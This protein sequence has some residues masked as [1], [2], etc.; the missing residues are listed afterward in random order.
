MTGAVEYRRLVGELAAA[1][2]RRDMELAAAEGS[3]V[4][5]MAALDK[6]TVRA[7]A[8]VDAAGARVAAARAGIEA[9]DHTAARLWEAL[10]TQLGWR[11]RL[12]AR[13]RSVW[14]ESPAPS[15][16]PVEGSD[17]GSA[18]HLLGRAAARL[19]QARRGAP[20]GVLPRRALP[21]LPLF[22]A[23]GAV[24]AGLVAGGLAGLGGVVLAVAGWLLFLA[25]PFAGLPAARMWAARW[26]RARLDTGAIGLT[27]IG[28]M[29]ACSVLVIALRH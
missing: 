3:S 13:S 7:V 27:V 20:A 28:G 23:A 21:V 4:D 15:E 16:S 26:H 29:I 22:G 19:A 10:R 9:T 12:V 2:H 1:A 6:S 14:R 8:A 18:E 17:S 25:A 5:A 24:A 11:A